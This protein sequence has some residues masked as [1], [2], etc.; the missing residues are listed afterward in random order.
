MKWRKHGLIFN[1]SEHKLWKGC[2][3]FAQSPQAL[4]LSDR[5]RVYFSTRERVGEKYLSHIAFVDFNRNLNEIKQVSDHE[6]IGLGDLGCFDEHGIFPMSP[7]IVDDKVF[8]YTCGWSQRVSVSVETSIGLAISDDNGNTFNRH[9]NG[10]ILSSSLNEPTLVGDGF[11]KHFDGSFHMWYIFG[12]GWLEETKN[13]PPA[14]VYKIGH[15]ISE[16]GIHWNKEEGVEI[17]S[18]VLGPTE[19]QALPSVV[20]FENT[21]HMVF[22]YRYATDF[23]TNPERGYRL[24]YAYSTNLKDWTRDDSKLGIDFEQ[25]EWDSEM[26]CYPNIF[27]VDEKVYLLYNGNKFGISGFGLAELES[28]S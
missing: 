6:V 12:L 23:R 26:Q 10:P 4:V 7:L 11:V 27:K 5:I 24:G 1:P 18:D 21:Y 19:C 8:A 2:N 16:D 3:Q 20:M 14:R 28:L 13:E 15:A 17:I 25:G 9:T 22:C